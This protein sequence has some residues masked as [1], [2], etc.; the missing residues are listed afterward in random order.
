MSDC[1]P[2]STWGHP[3]NK[4]ILPLKLFRIRTVHGLHSSRSFSSWGDSRNQTL[5]QIGLFRVKELDKEEEVLDE[6]L[7]EKKEAQEDDFQGLFE[8]FA[9]LEYG[10]QSQ[11]DSILIEKKEQEDDFQG[12]LELFE[13]LEYECH[14]LPMLLSDRTGVSRDIEPCLVRSIKETQQYP[15]TQGKGM[16]LPRPSSA[17]GNPRNETQ[18]E[19]EE[20]VL[21]RI[22]VE[23]EV[24][25]EDYLQGCQNS[26]RA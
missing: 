5:P 12:L 2:S 4:N 9:E 15:Q 6:I 11:F 18:L 1:G 23:R 20:E 7:V 10:K 24:A 17:L 8:L 19:R 21:N 3:Q 25:Q 26:L 13:G 14:P 16:Y 22:L